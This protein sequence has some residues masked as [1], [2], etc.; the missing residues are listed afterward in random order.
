M[1]G[2]ILAGGSGTRLHPITRAVSKQ[3]LPVYDKPMIYYPLSVL[4]LAG[5]DDILI[6]TTPHDREQFTRLLGDGSDYGI[7][8]SYAVQP[9]PNGL[10]EAFVIGREHVGSE[11]AALVLGDNIFYG[12]LLG[13]MLSDAAELTKGC[14]LF[15]YRVRDPERYGVAEADEDGR[16]L[17]IEEKPVAPRSDLAVTGLY[18]YDNDVCD[19]AASLKP[20][21]RGELEITDLNNVYVERGDAELV[22]LGRG[23]AWLDT[24]THDSLLEAGQ[25]VQVL[26][27]RQGVRIAC[28]EEIALAKGWIDAERALGLGE[29]LAK[30]GYGQYVIDVARRELARRQ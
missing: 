20:S 4:M 29:A 12:H 18:F 10:A 22:D 1:K 7:S 15:G 28:L 16:L 11:S 13:Q 6:I 19:I 5:I 30:S 3:L 26:E 17:S 21:S 9:E 27:H 24:G 25:F 2:I 14:K 8:L 23:T